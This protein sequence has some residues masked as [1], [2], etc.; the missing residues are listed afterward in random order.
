MHYNALSAASCA[1]YIL[2][3]VELYKTVYT[4]YNI[5]VLNLFAFTFPLSETADS[6]TWSFIIYQPK[7]QYIVTLLQFF[8][9]INKWK[10]DDWTRYNKSTAQS[11]SLLHESRAFI[12]L[13]VGNV[14]VAWAKALSVSSHFLHFLFSR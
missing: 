6:D 13:R 10:F 8:L 12:P 4:V 1:V 2:N 14:H 5:F 7:F 11:L 3:S 9:S